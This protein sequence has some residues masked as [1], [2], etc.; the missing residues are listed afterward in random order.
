MRRR[1]TEAASSCEG[2]R[3]G[4]S[5]RAPSVPKSQFHSGGRE[6]CSRPV[7][8]SRETGRFPAAESAYGAAYLEEEGGSWGK[9]SFPCGSET[10]SSDGRKGT[11]RELRCL[12][13]PGLLPGP[14]RFRSRA[15]FSS[16]ASRCCSCFCG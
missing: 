12:P 13:W 8:G 15:G 4:S 7:E 6:L 14:R 9:P 1:V 11:T 16:S 5:A 2:T 10:K 3:H